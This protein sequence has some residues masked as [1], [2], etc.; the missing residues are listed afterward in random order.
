MPTVATRSQSAGP[1]RL[2]KLTEQRLHVNANV[3]VGLGVFPSEVCGDSFHL[4]AR[5]LDG[6]AGTE[7]GYRCVAKSCRSRSCSGG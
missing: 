4:R 2:R 5:L 6:D 7:A 3:P 1:C